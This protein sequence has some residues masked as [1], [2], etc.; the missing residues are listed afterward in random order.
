MPA[1]S[2]LAT[3][4]V[5]GA[6]AAN[7]LFI[8]AALALNNVADL[9]TDERHD[10]K[11]YLADATLRVGRRRALR[12][13]VAELALATALSV[14]VAV[15]TGH[16][17]VTAVA[18]AIVLLTL[19]YNIEPIR[20]KRRGF[21]G[22]LVFGTSLVG[23]PCLLSYGAVR[24]GFETSVWPVFAGV[25]VLTIG[26]TVW[27]SVPDRA[28]D[29]ATGVATPS[30]RHGAAH[31]LALA[32]VVLLAGLALLGWGLW[33]RYGPAWALAG[34]LAHGVFLVRVAALLRRARDGELPTARRMHTRGLP[35]VM[36]GEVALLVVPLAA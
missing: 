2:G 27:W 25:A 22:P 16:W 30:A 10:E 20:L 6:I 28:A 35:V 7:L 26:R 36:L 12:W 32:C 15:R 4:P 29:T 23:L 5:L 24:S 11:S 34:T 33:W 9:R 8:V 3:L 14:A 1:A 19:S 18:A 21:A 17:V 31:T 13:V